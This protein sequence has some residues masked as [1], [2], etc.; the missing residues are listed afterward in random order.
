MSIRNVQ[1]RR[2]RM[3]IC[4]ADKLVDRLAPPTRQAIEEARKKQMDAVRE[5]R[6][7]LAN[8]YRAIR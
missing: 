7:L 8:A 3:I 1:L 2:D 5:L 4:E 6:R